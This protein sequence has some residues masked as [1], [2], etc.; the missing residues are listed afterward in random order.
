MAPRI[1]EPPARRK[2]SRL[3]ERHGKVVVDLVDP[4][5][6][7]LADA[8]PKLQGLAQYAETHAGAYRRIVSVAAANGK[9]RALDLTRPEVRKAIAEAKDAAGLFAG[10]LADDYG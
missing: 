1:G 6:L 7:H 3:N 5:G 4:H 2:L 9:V 8:L 10:R